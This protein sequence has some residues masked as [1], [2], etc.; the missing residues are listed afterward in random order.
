VAAT[1]PFTNH[2]GP[3]RNAYQTAQAKQSCGKYVGNRSRRDDS[4]V[5]EQK[6]VEEPL[7]G[8][9]SNTHVEANVCNAM[10]AIV[11]T[12][13]YNQ[14][15]SI[16]MNKSALDR[17]LFAVSYFRTEKTEFEKTDIMRNPDIKTTMDIKNGVSY[18][19]LIDGIVPVGTIVE[20]NDVLIGKIVKLSK[21]HE[22]FQF[23][24]KSVVYKYDEPARVVRTSDH[25]SSD[26]LVYVKVHMVS[27]R[28][29]NQGDK[30]SAR[31]G[32]KSILAKKSPASDMIYM[33]DGTPI[34]MVLNCHAIPTRMI[35]GQEIESLVATIAARKGAIVDGTPFTPVD[36]DAISKE[37]ESL[38]LHPY[39]MRVIYNGATGQRYDAMVFSGEVAYQ[40]LQKFIRDETYVMAT[41]PTC[42]TTRQPLVGKAKGG[43]LRY[44]EM[45]KD[46][47]V[48]HGS[49]RLLYQK[50]S[51]D[52]DGFTAYMCKC[53]HRAVIVNPKLN[54]YKCKICK[55]NADIVAVPSMWAVN[56]FYHEL[57][58]MNIKPKFGL[59]PYTFY[60]RGTK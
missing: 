11:C 50:L 30:C 56:V 55:S 38:G 59:K 32:C 54:F 37:A 57:S 9:I 2:S 34:T 22:N 14:E 10:V 28:P 53:G 52:S 4:R 16:I 18:E 3:I 21:P 27:Y 49:M 40:R 8:T 35:I 36:L 60:S 25:I 46:V 47:T 51:T 23:S 20:K 58:A 17:G 41:G 26:G 7:V 5:C 39:G 12:D 24:D 15:D 19:K 33:E 44:G 45:E 48:S 42:A 6:Y 1:S 31:S 43:G 13:G 29:M